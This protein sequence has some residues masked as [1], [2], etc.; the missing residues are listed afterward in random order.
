M[1]DIRLQIIDGMS[2]IRRV[3][4][5]VPG[6]EHTEERAEQA[7]ISCVGSFNRCLNSWGATHVLCVLDASGNNWRHEVYPDYKANRDP[8]PTVLTDRL[9]DLAEHLYDMSI[10]TVAKV[11]YEADDIIGSIAVK[12]APYCEQIEI[13][14]NDKDMF[15]LIQDNITV[16]R[17]FA[18]PENG[19]QVIIDEK[20]I[21][22]KYGIEPTQFRDY[23][24]LMGDKADNVPGVLGVGHKYAVNLLQ[25]NGSLEN[26]LNRLTEFEAILS[27][28]ETVDR[29]SKSQEAR[30]VFGF[31]SVFKALVEH[32]N[33][34]I[35]SYDLVGFRDVDL[36]LS[37]RD[38]RYERPVHKPA[39]RNRF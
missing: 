9:V 17:H 26:L 15:Q 36:A 39:A 25:R 30:D 13:V 38:I 31:P 21:I 35:L 34:L 20:Y 32:K 23:L 19:E 28:G 1:A 22:D 18:K 6:D 33:N 37:L 14:S 12:L 24:A 3:Y 27:K 10:G 5:A 8:C 2:I 29:V 16:R 11:G 4:E 7:V